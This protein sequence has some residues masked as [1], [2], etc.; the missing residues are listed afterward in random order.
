[1]SQRAEVRVQMVKVTRTYRGEYQKKCHFSEKNAK[2]DL[3]AHGG[4]DIHV[5]EELAKR[6]FAQDQE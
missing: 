5:K 3:S 6:I 2:E 1:M 4:Y